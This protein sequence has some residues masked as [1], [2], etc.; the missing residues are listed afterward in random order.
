MDFKN[1]AGKVSLGLAAAV[2]SFSANAAEK[3]T[4]T[5]DVLPILQENCQDCH[6]PGGA[7][8][9]GMVAPMAFMSYKEVRPWAKAIQKAVVSKEMPPWDAAPEFDGHFANQRT[10]TQSEIDTIVEWVQS[11]VPRGA[12]KDA[13]E[14]RQWDDS[15]DWT[16]GKVDLVSEMPEAY[17]VEDDVQDIY[18]NFYDKLTEE[19]LATDRYIKAVEFKPGSSVVHHIISNPLGG[20]APGNDPNVNP[21]G[22]GSIIRKGTSVSFDMHYH[23]EP[24]AG[25][26]TWDQSSA[27]VVFYPEGYVPEHEIRSSL[28]ANLS[29]RI[30][31]GDSNYVEHASETFDQEIEIM[32]FTP[33]MHLRGKSAKYEVKY[34]D[35][36]METLL[37]VPAYDFNWQTSY[38]YSEHKV[39]PAGSS[40]ELTMA[41][42]NSTENPYNPDPT[43]DVVFGEPTTD[44][45]FF[46][47]MSYA[48]VDEPRDTRVSQMV[49]GKYIGKYKLEGDLPMVLTIGM[50]AGKLTVAI[51][52]QDPTPLMAESETRFSLADLGLTIT[53][54]TI[55]GGL[56]KSLQ[57]KLLGDTHTAVKISD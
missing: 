47:F 28:L 54:D 23:K 6:R 12:A 37:E 51:P 55:E 50:E 25:T 40:V 4:F 34:P 18:V 3:V 21:E 44:E 16:I 8:L 41:W 49:L 36:T 2:M 29:F 53:F 52:G 22:Y 57:A 43:K 10:L 42:D 17:F 27:G 9:G 5:K 32:G 45:M 48:Y 26:G 35:G 19:E 15:S 14:P 11:G 30:P 31:A 38:K 33:H 39:L 46:G 20:I 7:N 13:P 24:G 1:V 56:A